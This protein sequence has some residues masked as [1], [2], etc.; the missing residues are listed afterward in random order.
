MERIQTKFE[1]SRDLIPV[2]ESNNTVHY[3]LSQF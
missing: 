1:V 3:V 2:I